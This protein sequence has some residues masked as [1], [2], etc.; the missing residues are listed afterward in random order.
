MVEAPK[1]KLPDVPVAAAATK[2]KKPRRKPKP[3]AQTAQGTGQSAGTQTGA[4]AAGTAPGGSGS[5]IGGAGAG[6]GP[7][8]ATAEPPPNEAGIAALGA[9]T[10]GGGDQSPRARQEASDLIAATEKRINAL[11]KD[12]AKA[13]AAQINKV[14]NFLRE[15][16]SALRSGDAEGART[17]AMKGK[18]LLDDVEKAGGD[19]AGGG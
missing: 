11:P 4:G 17:L 2:P 10:P 14:R 6:A 9:L 18:L 1:Q 3:A 13:Q 16:Q 5:G 15:A 8:M 12:T 7:Q 19:K